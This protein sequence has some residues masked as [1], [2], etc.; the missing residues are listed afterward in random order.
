MSELVFQFSTCQPESWLARHVGFPFDPSENIRRATRSPYS[1]VDF[2]L[3]DENL[4][5]ASDSPAAPV[6][7]GNPRGVAIRPPNYQKFGIRRRA[8]IYTD[9][10]R[11]ILALARA[12][13][14]KPFDHA[15]LKLK[16]MLSDS[17]GNRDWRD[18]SQWYCAEL[19]VFCCEQEHLWPFPLVIQKD[20][21]TA[22]DFLCYLN[23]IM[24]VARFLAPIPN[25]QLCLGETP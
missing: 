24:D 19:G 20:R 1:H 7:E 11:S 12:Q 25:I 17:W 8:A 18:P 4:L 14:G 5:G 16:H 10:A 22:G 2:V 6:V 3:L 21:V 23:P 9:K 15:A 13:V